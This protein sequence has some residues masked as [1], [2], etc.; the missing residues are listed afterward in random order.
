VP[1]VVSNLFEGVVNPDLRQGL[2]CPKAAAA[3]AFTSFQLYPA[4]ARPETK[5]RTFIIVT[6]DMGGRD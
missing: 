6:A 5:S 3:M 2:V 4:L 1:L